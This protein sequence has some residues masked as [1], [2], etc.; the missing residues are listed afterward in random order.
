MIEAQAL[1]GAAAS[2]SQIYWFLADFF[3]AAPDAERLARLRATLAAAGN[4]G[5]PAFAAAMRLL[6]DD[7][8]PGGCAA[9]AVEFTRLFGGLR[10]GYGP[11]PPYES[12]QREG[13]LVG[14]SAEAV[15]AAY[16]D[17]GFDRV[18]P[19]AT[20]HDHLGAELRFM[21][22]LCYREMEAWRDGNAADAAGWLQR[23]QRFLDCHLL[24]WVPDYCCVLRECTTLDFYRGVNELSVAALARDHEHIVHML[25]DLATA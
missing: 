8:A 7:A 16:R 15:T 12:V 10:E 2:R 19:D 14:A 6:A 25:R 18:A 4:E 3:L 23:Q 5:D 24:R 20:P 21:A 17:A 22:L 9:L 13:T 1:E 11:P